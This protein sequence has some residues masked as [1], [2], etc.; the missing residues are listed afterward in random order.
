LLVTG[1]TRFGQ[2]LAAALAQLL[3]IHEVSPSALTSA[4]GQKDSSL[5][6]RVASSSSRLTIRASQPEPAIDCDAITVHP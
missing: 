4:A 3:I 6:D 1:T 5:A 2:S